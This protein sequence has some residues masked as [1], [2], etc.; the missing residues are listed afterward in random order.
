VQRQNQGTTRSNPK[1]ACYKRWLGG[2]SELRVEVGLLDPM[3]QHAL[4]QGAHK[5]NVGDMEGMR[6]TCTASEETNN[7]SKTVRDDRP[8]VALL[9]ERAGLDVELE[10]G[11]FL[12]DLNAAVALVG[13]VIRV[14][15]HCR[16]SDQRCYP[17]S[18]P[19][20]TACHLD[21]VLSGDAC[22]RLR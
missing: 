9:R 17:A 16:Q 7:T 20:G 10:D 18:K 6:N 13:A 12:G 3:A 21:R 22:P 14:R 2:K 1:Y 8:R 5:H 11:P 19:E 15:W 4:E